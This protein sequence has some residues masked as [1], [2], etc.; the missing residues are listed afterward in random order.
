MQPTRSGDSGTVV[1]ENPLVAS[2]PA[3]IGPIIERTQPAM[4]HG[5]SWSGEERR[6]FRAA[7][8]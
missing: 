3:V 1:E 7:T 4:H 2:Y 6:N 5:G 8:M